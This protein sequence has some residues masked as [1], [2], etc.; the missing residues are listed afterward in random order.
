MK[1]HMQSTVFR[2]DEQDLVAVSRVQR[3]GERQRRGEG[4]EKDEKLNMKGIPGN[5]RRLRLLIGSAGS[6][7]IRPVIALTPIEISSAS[8]PR[9]RF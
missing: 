5:G 7:A 1:L 8:S 3:V 6:M 2:G 9:E 4:Q